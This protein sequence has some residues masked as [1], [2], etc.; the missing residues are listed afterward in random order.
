[1]PWEGEA[2]WCC[3][4]YRGRDGAHGGWARE[5]LPLAALLFAVLQLAPA[6]H[7]Q[8]RAQVQVAHA[9]RAEAEHEAVSCHRLLVLD[10][11]GVFTHP[12]VLPLVQGRRL[13]TAGRIRFV[14]AFIFAFFASNFGTDARL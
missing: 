10:R 14:F 8:P 12:V 5:A 11:V 6:L 3:V 9:V 1:M 2:K 7:H 13:L 4:I